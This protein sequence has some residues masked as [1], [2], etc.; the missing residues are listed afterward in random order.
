MT[1]IGMLWV[2]SFGCGCV[3]VGD[4]LEKDT[5]QGSVEEGDWSHFTQNLLHALKPA[6]KVFDIT[7]ITRSVTADVADS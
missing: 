6:F 1:W 7:V 5:E 4:E 3:F 2:E